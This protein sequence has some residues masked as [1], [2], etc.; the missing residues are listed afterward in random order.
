MTD[1]VTVPASDG[2]R[3]RRAPVRRLDALDH[4]IMAEL[5][6]DGRRTYR[7][8]SQRLNVAPGT[9]RSRVLQLLEEG[10]FRV[11]AIPDPWKMGY[12]FHAS[13]GLRL[14]PGK[15]QAVG[16]FLAGRDEVTWVG[17]V[18]TGYDVI[19]EVTLPDSRSFGEYKE[20]V[21][22]AL[23]GVQQVDVFEIWSIQ[24]FRYNMAPP[25]RALDD[26]MADR[27]EGGTA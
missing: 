22:A 15:A 5:Q 9:I 7:E 14:L 10:V 3:A 20:K 16:S 18:S 11:I 24:K 2:D 17:L 8:M 13:V 1:L 27:S 21:L 4:G 25:E 19:F 26:A 12:Q 6:E 23:D